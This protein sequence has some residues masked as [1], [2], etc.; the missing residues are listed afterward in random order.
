MTWKACKYKWE[1][2][3]RYQNRWR[4]L[5]SSSNQGG[6]PTKLPW[7]W[8]IQNC[9]YL[10]RNASTIKVPILSRHV[11]AHT[12]IKWNRGG[13]WYP[14]FL[15]SMGVS[16]FP[17][18]NK[19]ICKICI[20]HPIITKLCTVALTSTMSTS[21]HM[22]IHSIMCVNMRS[23]CMPCMVCMYMWSMFLSKHRFQTCG[24]WHIGSKW[25][26]NNQHSLT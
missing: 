25:S 1:F 13:F 18:P 3:D 5:S 10:A 11:R 23:M 15:G 24:S 20:M 6:P 17:N 12:Y 19:F 26:P 16:T 9:H 21:V 22:I 4:H 8:C 7:Q 14:H 2:R